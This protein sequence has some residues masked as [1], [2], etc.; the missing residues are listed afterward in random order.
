MA[1]LGQRGGPLLSSCQSIW[2]SVAKATEAQTKLEVG[3][4][5]LQLVCS[6]SFQVQLP[7]WTPEPSVFQG[8]RSLLPQQRGGEGGSA[9]ILHRQLLPV[10]GHW[11]V[12]W[13]HRSYASP[14]LP[15]RTCT[16]ALP[17]QSIYTLTIPSCPAQVSCWLWTDSA[18]LILRGK[19]AFFCF[20]EVKAICTIHLDR[21]TMSSIYFLCCIW[22]FFSYVPLSMVKTEW[23]QTTC[24]LAYAT[25]QFVHSNWN[26]L[27]RV[28]PSQKPQQT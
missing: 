17:M 24:F 4:S 3:Q 20:K 2:H 23:L 27:P 7:P 19:N 16:H 22:L 8:R 26:L 11:T 9:R 13:A 1:S 25:L 6:V 10:P 18:S 5:S 14:Q 21:D 15:G 12:G 28:L